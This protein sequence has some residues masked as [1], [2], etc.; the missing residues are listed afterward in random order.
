MSLVPLDERGR[1]LHAVK[2]TSPAA[3]FQRQ[4]HDDMSAI[5]Q[6]DKTQLDYNA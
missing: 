4:R 6:D 2:H 5:L 3:I 1:K